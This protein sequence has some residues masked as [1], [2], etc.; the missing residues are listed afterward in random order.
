MKVFETERLIVRWMNLGDT[1]FVIDI[2]NS[3]GWIKNIGDRKVRTISDA[4]EYLNSKVLPDYKS[5]GFGMYL[6]ERKSDGKCI[7]MTGLVDRPG[8]DGIDIGFALLDNETGKGYAFEAS[9]PLIPHAKEQEL[10]LLK[11][12]T[13]P[14]NKPS[15][16]LLEKLGFLFVKDFYMDGDD[17]L[18]SLYELKL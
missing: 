5:S 17:D 1:Q 14:S 9:L 16:S 8:L 3:R 11:A 4:E 15:R 12:I 6:I 13:R 18:L 10:K 2:L 7:G